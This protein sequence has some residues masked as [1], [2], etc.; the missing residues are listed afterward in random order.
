MSK[1]I[2]AFVND[3]ATI[4]GLVLVFAAFLAYG[5]A[6]TFSIVSEDGGKT[7]KVV[8]QEESVSISPSCCYASAQ[9]T[10]NIQQTG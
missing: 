5:K 8:R 10:G 3:R 4:N 1:M 7:L 2:V 6:T 9:L